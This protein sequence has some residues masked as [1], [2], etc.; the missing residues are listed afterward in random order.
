LFVLFP[1][2]SPNRLLFFPIFVSFPLPLIPKICSSLRFCLLR[3]SFTFTFGA[4]FS[5]PL[6]PTEPSFF[7]YALPAFVRIS[8]SCSSTPKVTALLFSL[9]KSPLRLLSL[10]F[11]YAPAPPP[12]PVPDGEFPFVLIV[13]FFEKFFMRFLPAGIIPSLQLRKDFSPPLFRP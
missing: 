4:F 11:C 6:F 2:F 1:Q 13:L 3:P 10:F 8:R 7:T 5:L 12:L 9:P